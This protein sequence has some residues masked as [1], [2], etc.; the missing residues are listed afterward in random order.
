MRVFDANRESR[1]ATSDP[2][3]ESRTATSDPNRESRTATSDPKSFAFVADRSGS[4]SART[5]G[6]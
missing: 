3:R 6:C 5:F 1:T 2:N 4:D